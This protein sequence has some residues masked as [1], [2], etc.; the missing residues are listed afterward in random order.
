MDRKFII[1]IG[2]GM[3]DW[4]VPSLGDKT[5]LEA[6]NKP[7]MDFM[8]S[9]G[10]LGMVQVVPKDMYPGSDV[11]NLSIIGYDPREVYTGRSPLEAASMGVELA[12]DDVA[13]R[14]NVVALKNLGA[15]S[16]ME[17]FSAGHIGTGEAAELL[18]ALQERVEERGVRFYPGVSYRHLMVWPGGNA[19]VETTPPH[20]IHG[21]NITEYL[22]KGEGA[23]FL[24]ELMEISREIFPD[25]PV[26]RKRVEAGKP[27]G[28]SIWLWGQG[29]APRMQ[30]FREKYGLSGSV[31]AAVDLIRG[32]GVYA[33]LELVT[34]PGATGYIDTNFRGKAEYALRE[35]ESKD[36]VLIHVEAPDEAGHNGSAPDKVRAIERIDEEMLSPILARAKSDGNLTVLVLP[37]HPTPV[38][39]RTHS[40]EPVPFA[41]YPAP[42]GLSS[43]P[44]KRY[45]EADAK[46]TGQFLDAGTRLIGYLLAGRNA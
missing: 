36:F 11:S 25:H 43:F 40:Q 27:P 2:D 13:V 14:C 12:E 33:G 32:I 23:E 10:A 45:T 16:E 21:K 20:D 22:P 6:A 8:A 29:K 3:A 24:L 26:N 39:I 19:A 5:P 18:R 4:P 41:F 9:Q 35:L 1:L 15:R 34:V 42:S 30:T 46:A 44:D 7:H 38:A 31:V 37:D 28:N 17:D